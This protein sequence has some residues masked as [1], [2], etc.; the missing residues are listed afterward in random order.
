MKKILIIDDESD[1]IEVFELLLTNLN[2]EVVSES[3]PLNA[4]KMIQ[5]TQPDLVILDWLMPQMEGI[6]VLRNIKSTLE[7][8]EIPVI[9]SSGIRTQSSNLQT[10]LSVGAIDFLKKPIDEIELEARVASAIKLYD[11]LRNTQKMQQEIHAKEM[12][13]EQNK[14]LFYQNELNKKNREMLVS[15]VTIFQN[16]KLVSILKS[17]IFDEISELSEE[18]KS[19]VAKV[20]DRYENISSSINWDMFEKR[21]TELNSEFYNK[22]NVEFPDL[23][24]GEQRLCAFFKLG[25]STKEIAIINYS[26]Y[27]AIRK[28]I[29]RIRKKLNQNEKIDLNLF[30]QA[31]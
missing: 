25:L 15:A 29:Y 11:Y 21:F 1:S 7:I 3:N 28:A 19:L 22:L 9:I 26:S 27:E 6:E 24:T 31:F 8:K 5:T 12:Q 20:L 2:Y 23:S 30:F 18:H 10:A 13:I 16:K 14:A 17:E 4:I